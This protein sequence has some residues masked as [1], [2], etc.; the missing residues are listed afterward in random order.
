MFQICRD[1]LNSVS[2]ILMDDGIVD[3][4]TKKLKIYCSWFD[5]RIN[6]DECLASFSFLERGQHYFHSF[7]N[8]VNFLNSTS[9]ILSYLV[10]GCGFIV[11]F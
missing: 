2:V 3:K 9:F 11:P 7:R 5:F 10:G 1:N 8:S 6:E 4:F